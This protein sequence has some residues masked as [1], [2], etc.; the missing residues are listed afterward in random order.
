MQK[1]FA[2]SPTVGTYDD[3]VTDRDSAR[4]FGDY[5]R[6]AR[7]VS[8]LRILRQRNPVYGQD[9]DLRRISYSGAFGVSELTAGKGHAVLKDKSF[10]LGSP[11]AGEWG[12]SFELFLVDHTGEPS[13]R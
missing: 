10:L 9:S 8:E 2:V 5:L 6:S 7:R 13:V 4:R 12:E 1:K 3:G 11:L